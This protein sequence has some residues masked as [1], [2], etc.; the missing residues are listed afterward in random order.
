MSPLSL[1]KGWGALHGGGQR[2]K[3]WNNCN[4][5]INKICLKNIYKALPYILLGKIS[6]ETVY[7]FMRVGG[8]ISFAYILLLF[9]SAFIT[10]YNFLKVQIFK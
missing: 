3:N 6:C 1:L 5:T 4:S 7:V 2:E 9:L 10:F 8:F